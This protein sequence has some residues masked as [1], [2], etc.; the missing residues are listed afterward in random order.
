M[1][2]STHIGA[3]RVGDGVHGE[4]FEGSSVTQLELDVG[5]D[6]LESVGL[7]RELLGA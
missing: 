2:R 6:I 1:R 3:R 5:A 4:E 7:A